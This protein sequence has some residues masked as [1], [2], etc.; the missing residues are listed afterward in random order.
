M[1]TVKQA[2]TVSRIIGKLDLKISDPKAGANEVGADLMMQLVSKAHKASEDIYKLV[3]E[4][5]GC[6]VKEAEDV[7]IVAIFEDEKIM[8]GKLVSFFTSA[9]KQQLQE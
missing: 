7:D 6:T 2:I 8:G 1:F 9:V 3:A 4:L 5:K